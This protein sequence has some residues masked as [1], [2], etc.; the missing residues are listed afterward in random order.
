MAC[1]YLFLA[2]SEVQ[3]NTNSLVFE[4]SIS[5]QCV[6]V[7]VQNGDFTDMGNHSYTLILERSNEMSTVPVEIYPNIIP[8]FV[9]DDDSQGKIQ[10]AFMTSY[11]YYTCLN[12]MQSL[13]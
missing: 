3:L 8:I 4:Q 5:E 1:A 10:R 6:M 9:I 2:S 12:L 11:D 7:T 13:T